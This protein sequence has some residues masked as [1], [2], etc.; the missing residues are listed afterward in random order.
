MEN[1]FCFIRAE[2][3]ADSVHPVRA[4]PYEFSFVNNLLIVHES[5]QKGCSFRLFSIYSKIKTNFQSNIQRGG[6]L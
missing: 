2:G 6:L 4:M 5:V 3:I 1:P